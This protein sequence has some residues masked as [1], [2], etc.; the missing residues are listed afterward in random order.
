[1]S[2]KKLGIFS[3]NVGDPRSSARKI[4]L[5]TRRLF[6]P[7]TMVSTSGSSGIGHCSL[8]RR[9]VE[10]DVRSQLIELNSGNRLGEPGESRFA[11]SCRIE[12]LE[13]ALEAY[14]LF[15]E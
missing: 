13:G 14:S 4:V 5:P 10:R 12:S 15:Y 7:R 11:M 2:F 8:L 9:L 6:N 3:R 1:M